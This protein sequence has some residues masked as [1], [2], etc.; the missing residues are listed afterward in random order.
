[1]KRIRLSI[2]IIAKNE[3][4]MIGEA[5]KSA[6][7]ADEVLVLDNG[8]TDNTIG[9]AKQLG[10]KVI[11]QP[12]K[13][14]EFAQWRTAVMKRAKGEWIFYLDADE[15]ITPKLRNEIKKIISQAKGGVNA[16]AVPRKNFYLGKQ[17]KYGGAW[18][19][20]VKRFFWKPALKKWRGRLHEEPVFKGKMAYLKNPIEHYTHR[21]LTSMLEKTI[22]WSKLEA[23]EL[24]KARHPPMKWWRFI[25][26]MF[27]E[28]WERGIKKQ[29]FRDG[30]VGVIEVIFQMFSRFITYAR[31]WEMQ[32]KASPAREG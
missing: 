8:S 20:Y 18:P 11:K 6:I 1:M 4:E 29:G 5:I 17:V 28:L 3:Q 30:T 22:E 27:A 2:L 25:K 26:I 13:T 23:A 15:R 14:I 31:L 9:I 12:T 10:V 7:W 16:Y 19:D 24:Y 21:D 32:N